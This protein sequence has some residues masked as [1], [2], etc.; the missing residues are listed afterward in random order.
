VVDRVLPDQI[1]VT[2]A[3]RGIGKAVA[4]ALA[5]KG[6]TIL[7]LSKTISC[8]RTKEEIVAS[9]GQAFA[10][11]IDFNDY[12]DVHRKVS[13]WIEEQNAARIGIVTAAAMLGPRGPL[14]E[15]SLNDWETTFRVNLLGNLAVVKAALPTMERQ[16]YGRIVMLAG[17]GSAYAFPSFQAYA[18]SK[19]ALVREVENLAEDLAEKGDIAIHCLAP[20]AIETDMLAEV[21]RAGGQVRTLGSISKVI[22]CVETLLGN[23][24][25]VLSG[26]FLHVLDRWAEQILKTAQPLSADQWKLRRIE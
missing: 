11:S 23:D 8:Q 12:Q 7:C 25:G 16:G 26:R 17:G 1:I 20:G 10:A 24:T 15:T 22:A 6:S 4:L 18:C 19:T 9:G 14:T 21:R 13:D 5:E 3:G 2:G